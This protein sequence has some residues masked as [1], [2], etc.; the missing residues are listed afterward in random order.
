MMNRED[1]GCLLIE[2]RG[3]IFHFNNKSCCIVLGRCDAGSLKAVSKPPMAAESFIAN[4]YLSLQLA[5]QSAKVWL[6]FA[7]IQA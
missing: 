7:F 1:H 3:Q 2:N 6:F 5:K 4:W